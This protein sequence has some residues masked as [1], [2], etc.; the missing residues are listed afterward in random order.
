MSHDW[1]RGVTKFGNTEKLLRFKKHFREEVAEDR[2]GSGPTREVIDQ[3]VS[4]VLIKFFTDFGHSPAR[5]LVCGTSPLQIRCPGAAWREGG[6]ADQVFGTGQVPAE[7]AVP[8]GA[9]DRGASGE[10]G[11]GVIEVRPRLAGNPEIHQPLAFSGEE[12]TISTWSRLLRKVAQDN[13]NHKNG[14]LD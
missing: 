6:E 11:G 7:T 8:P 3:H 13:N 5:V 4:F 2:L 10:G 14:I 12:T 9:R 1:P